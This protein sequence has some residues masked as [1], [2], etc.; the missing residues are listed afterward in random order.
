MDAD[1]IMLSTS[2]HDDEQRSSLQQVE[3]STHERDHGLRSRLRSSLHRSRADSNDTRDVQNQP[4]DRNLQAHSSK[5]LK[6]EHE[7][8]IRSIRTQMT[9]QFNE[10]LKCKESQGLDVQARLEREL[11]FAQ[12]SFKR[13]QT[14]L[15]RLQP[16]PQVT[17]AEI[18]T[19]FDELCHRVS[20]WIDEEI[21]IYEKLDG[22]SKQQA[23]FHDGGDKVLASYMR[24]FPA[25]GEYYVAYIVHSFLCSKIFNTK[26]YL[27]GLPSATVRVLKVVE[28]AMPHLKPPRGKSPA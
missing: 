4:K 12:D 5:T 2:T 25:F 1:H 23:L 24:E 7:A 10:V 28:E 3:I 11:A 18:L 21:A 6:L 26:T 17:D 8:Q 27:V 15:W 22:G 20:S 9:D 16:L 19:D 13:C 14:D